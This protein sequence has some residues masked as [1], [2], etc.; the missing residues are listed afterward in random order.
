MFYKLFMSGICLSSWISD[1]AS[2]INESALSIGDAALK[3]PMPPVTT[4]GLPAGWARLETHLRCFGI[5]SAFSH[6]YI[7]LKHTSRIAFPVKNENVLAKNRSRNAQ[8][9]L[10]LPQMSG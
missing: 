4:A 5:F 6:H 3:E 1:L 8:N 10:Q 9:I 2:R 7:F